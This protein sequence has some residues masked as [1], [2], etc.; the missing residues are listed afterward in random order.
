MKSDKEVADELRK[1][2]DSGSPN[3]KAAYEEMKEQKEA[4]SKVLGG[5]YIHYASLAVVTLEA[6]L[7]DLPA[8][9]RMDCFYKIQELL[10]VGGQLSILEDVAKGKVSP[11]KAAFGALSLCHNADKTLG[12]LQLLMKTYAKEAFLKMEQ[13]SAQTN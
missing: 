4:A 7:K 11:S 13:S 5:T 2:L 10:I 12:E 1:R 3:L 8:E 6:V 9:T